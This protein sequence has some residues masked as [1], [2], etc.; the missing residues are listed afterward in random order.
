M[1][2]IL[3]IIKKVK[4]AAREYCPDTRNPILHADRTLQIVRKLWMKNDESARCVGKT[5]FRYA[6]CINHLSAHT[7]G[8]CFGAL[9]DVLR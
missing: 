8:W 5:I 4:S 2:E 7:S 1:S 3:F 6:N 9:Y